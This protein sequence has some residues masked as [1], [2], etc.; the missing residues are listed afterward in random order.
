MD[1]AAI[2]VL[3]ILALGI[4]TVWM[5]V[6]SVPQGYEWPVER[7]GRYQRTLE[8]GLN[9]IVP[10][11]DQVRKKLNMM[12]TVLDIDSQEVITK[13]NAMVRADGVVF[14]QIVDAAKAAYEVNDLVRAINNLTMTNI[15]TV[16]GSM[17]LDEL[18]SQSDVVT[19]HVPETPATRGMIAA[20]QFSRMRPGAM[21]INASRGTVVDID[22]LVAALESK[23]VAGA[24]IGALATGQ[25]LHGMAIGAAAGATGGWLYNRHKEK[26][27]GN[28]Y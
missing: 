4:V 8:P 19:L 7:F 11:I 10:Y 17:D 13:D 3:V 28:S 26:E 5:G 6:K 12:E 21:L 1:T 9:L 27:A 14:F 25:P 16:M 15:R 22:A 18:L 2:F 20:E 24:A 23:Q